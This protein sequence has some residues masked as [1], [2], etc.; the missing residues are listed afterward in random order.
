MSLN[1][2]KGWEES[3]REGCAIPRDNLCL[4]SRTGHRGVVWR[5]LCKGHVS[6]C[7]NCPFLQIIS[8]EWGR[9]GNLVVRIMLQLS[10]FRMHTVAFL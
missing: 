7:L 3:W 1:K 4:F 9:E 2:G 6:A 8:K 10:L 5:R